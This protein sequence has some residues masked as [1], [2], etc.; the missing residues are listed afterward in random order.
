[1]RNSR[2]REKLRSGKTVL[3]T[4]INAADPVLVDI[5]GLLGFDCVWICREH[6]A[7]DND[8]LAHLIR[9]A[10]MRD[11]D[12]MVRTPRGSYSDFIQPLELGASGLMIPHC[13]HA[14]DARE[15]VRRT[16][17]HPLGRRPLDGGNSDGHYCMIPLADYLRQ[18]N[19]N[20]F[21]I[22]QIEDPE[23]V[24]EVDAIAAV[25]GIDCLFVGPGDLAHALGV[26]GQ[27]EHP[28]VACAIERV[29][30][31]CHRNGKAWGLPVT[32]DSAPRYMRM[33]ARFLTSGAD[34]L[35]L[36]AYFRD[37]R[38]RFEALGVEFAPKL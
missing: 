21:I 25:E 28:D 29:A 24:D 15:I 8:R 27:I 10:G 13:I 3:C 14:D 9:T 19:E 35:G 23:T 18:A 30:T 33:G 36:H 11:L 2:V 17:F 12:S 38:Q 22:V 4:K 37:L 31:A 20:T 32:A 26:P 16:R 5:I 1:M 34:V 6:G 7:I